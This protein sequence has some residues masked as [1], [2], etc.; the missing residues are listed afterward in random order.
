MQS[1]YLKRTHVNEEISEELAGQEVIL[2]GWVHQFRDL[3]GVIF[4]LMRDHTGLMQ[5]V[6]DETID[7]D[8][9]KLSEE[10]RFEYCIAV[11]GV[12][13]FR[14]VGQENP[15][16]KNGK[17]ELKVTRLEVLNPCQVLP[18]SVNQDAGE[19]K[20]I[21]MKYRY[22]EL[23]RPEIAKKIMMRHKLFMF[24][25]SY[26]SERDFCEIETPILAK[27]T[28]EGARDF[29]VP[30]RFS[31][32]QFY[33]L[34]QS[35][36]QFKQLLMVSGFSKYFQ[37]ARCLR[38]E[39][40]RADRQLEHTQLDMEM[41]FIE[42]EDV[43]NVVEGLY[44]SIW[45]EFL[46][47]DVSTPFPRIPYKKAI[48][49]YGID[50]P[51]LRFGMKIINLSEIFQKTS[52]KFLSSVLGEGGNILGLRFSKQSL[53]RSEIDQVEEY[54]K[55]QGA[56]GLAHFINDSGKIKSPLAKHLD[57][58][59]SAKIFEIL[60]DGG[61]LFVLAHGGK[62]SFQIL[63]QV[64]LMLGRKYELI[65]ESKHSLLW[66]TDFPLVQWSASE[67]KIVSEHHPF[68]KPIES[69]WRE[70]LDRNGGE[71]NPDDKSV[72]ELSSQAYDLVINGQEM[73]S[74]SIRINRPDLQR[75][76]FR[77]LGLSDEQIDT[78]FGHI[79]EAF[80]YGAPPHGGVAMGI[81]RTLIQ[82]TGDD[83]ITEVIPFPK[84]LKGVDPM[85]D[86]PSP[87][88]NEQLKELHIKL[89]LPEKS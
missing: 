56:S 49:E 85:M 86:S 75:Q 35:P 16:M 2:N 45:K 3:G 54:A 17:L 71:P 26:L 36:Q 60:K 73:G 39:D 83:A 8:S 79:L 77:L 7:I 25:R 57:D 47:Y 74:G 40:L 11:K 52:I 24:I 13:A 29:L 5:V 23:R 81:D 43:F 42:R 68:T 62:E 50:K 87:V 53:S 46:N 20:E 72:F 19:R 80:S 38:D 32:G 89:D 6:F 34:P 70:F 15:D 44:S 27:S 58:E 78:Q 66:V 69:E 55:E 63:G 14:P 48:E 12:V 31:P 67:K 51:D 30:S 76:I 37:L 82:I 59:E 61:I 65:N 22:L 21:R 10:L 41:S 1:T 4:A 84:T 18:V 28:P 64:R 9:R 88:S 33:A